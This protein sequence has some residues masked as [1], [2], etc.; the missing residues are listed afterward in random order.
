MA[1]QHII[2]VSM[3]NR[4]AADLLEQGLGT[5]WLE[6]EIGQFTAAASG[7]WYFSLKDDRAQVR[8]AMFKM[9]N[10]QCQLRP[11]QGDQVLVRAKVG[12]YQPRGEFQ[13]IV[14]SMQPAG[15]G[16]LQRAFEQLKSKLAGEGLFAAER[17]K[18]LPAMIQRLGVVT[19]SAGAAIHD[20]LT[21]LK[22]RDPAIEVIIYPT[23]VQGAAA[24]EQ[25]AEMI[26]LAAMRNEVDA[27][28]ITRGG[29]SLEDLWCFNE[30]R[31]ARAIAQ[32]ALP[33]IS[34]VGHEVDISI[35]DLVADMRSPTPSAAAELLS[36][37]RSDQ[38]RY[39][40]QLTERL[41]L[42]QAQY[43][44]RCQ[45]RWQ[46]LEQRL[47][48]CHPQRQ[49]GTR[50]QQ[51]DELTQRMQR[52]VGYQQQ[53]RQQRL[54]HLEQR[55]AQQHPQRSLQEA[56]QRQQ[57]LQQRLTQA[58]TGQLKQAQQQ[59]AQQTSLLDAVSPLGVLQRGYSLVRTKQKVVK[60]AAQTTPGQDVT[61]QFADGEVAAQ[62]TGQHQAAQQRED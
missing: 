16:R 17:K 6:A 2:T 21:V 8:C 7:H 38:L 48:R 11:K 26:N 50:M 19:S 30:E 5:V 31:V 42:Q 20:V 18:T 28:L 43:Q 53:Q 12:L 14:E 55:L 33:T 29:G 59:F 24:T 62:I 1:D 34:A 44:Q 3:L 56:S 35:A 37:D 32:C 25:I 23:A 9:R 27:L 40:K 41:R 49:L 57:Q 46:Q 51:L 61:L 58:M 4:T 60:R 47:Q 13:L 36:N 54:Q 10:R 52:A 39:F 15:I 22:K 45:Q